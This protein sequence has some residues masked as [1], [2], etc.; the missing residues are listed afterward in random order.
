MKIIETTIKK[1]ALIDITGLDP[2]SVF[3]EDFKPGQGKLTVECFGD[4]WSH[5]WGG[6]GERDFVGFLTTANAD[7]IAGKLFPCE[8]SRYVVDY[9]KISAEIGEDVD[10]HSLMLHE[11]KVADVYGGDWHHNLPNK[12]SHHWDYLYRIVVVIKE[13][14][15]SQLALAA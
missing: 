6:M 1:L 4:A 11:D 9:D 14:I 12:Q 2:I 8:L 3:L 5:Y 13:A 10:E 15:A 7:Y